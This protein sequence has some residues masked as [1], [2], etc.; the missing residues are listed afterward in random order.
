MQ[1]K[2]A[3]ARTSALV[4]CKACDRA[5]TTAATF[6]NDFAPREVTTS[7]ARSLNIVPVLFCMT[8]V[9]VSTTSSTFWDEAWPMETKTR[10]MSY[11]LCLRK[12]LRRKACVRTSTTNTAF[13]GEA[14]PMRIKAVIAKTWTLSL[15]CCTA[16]AR[17]STIRA[18]FPDAAV[19]KRPTKANAPPL[20]FTCVSGKACVRACTTSSTFSGA[21]MPMTPKSWN[22]SSSS[23]GLRRPKCNESVSVSTTGNASSNMV[24]PSRIRKISREE[25]LASPG[26]E[27]LRESFRVPCNVKWSCLSFT[28][29]AAPE[30]KTH[31]R[32]ATNAIIVG[33][34][35]QRTQ[36][37]R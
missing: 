18:T 14:L 16:C 21:A 24:G 10:H 35:E 5:C 3:K 36:Y 15:V 32:S 37:R 11:W 30:K 29:R 7:T 8:C 28:A 6:T 27:E 34:S 19:S 33:E 20:K 23:W 31:A 22:T 26:S 2:A 13:C 12:T 9:R 4:C 17:A 1:H 25:V